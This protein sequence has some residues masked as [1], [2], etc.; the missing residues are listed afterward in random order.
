MLIR[1]MR[2]NADKID[3]LYTGEI[4]EPKCKQL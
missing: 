3:E 1:M 2:Y 4:K